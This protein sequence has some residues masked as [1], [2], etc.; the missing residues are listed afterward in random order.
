MLP[1]DEIWVSLRNSSRESDLKK[2]TNIISNQ[3]GEI[4]SA[5]KS[6]LNS[7]ILSDV[8]F[9][10]PSDASGEKFDD[11]YGHKVVLAARCEYFKMLFSS[12]Y[13]E[14]TQTSIT[15]DGFSRETMLQLLEYIYTT[16]VSL[17]SQF[18]LKRA[19]ADTSRGN[20]PDP[21]EDSDSLSPRHGYQVHVAAVS[22]ANSIAVTEADDVG[23]LGACGSASGGVGTVELDITEGV[24]Q[25]IQLLLCANKY[26]L[27]A[28][29]SK[30]EEILY[31]YRT[32]VL[33]MQ[34]IC[35][36]M[37]IS[38][39]YSAK[40]LKEACERYIVENID[41]IK[42]DDQLRQEIAASPELALLLVDAM[43]SSNSSSGKHGISELSSSQSNKR[44]R[45]SYSNGN[46]IS[47]QDDTTGSP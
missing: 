47:Y 24:E 13:A 44:V 12:G 42:G 7:P 34:N 31:S 5:F 14:T 26:L 29:Q 3:E 36:F 28:L 41:L 18:P 27:P 21:I 2:N 22:S 37:Q 10:F 25:I 38:D 35:Q 23:D 6:F 17:F 19:S 15:V 1:N 43:T 32:D 33:T 45:L 8:A 16:D 46:S 4:A 20:S 11:V 9:R 40:R 39:K 30:C